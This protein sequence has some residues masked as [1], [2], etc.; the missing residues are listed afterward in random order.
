[1]EIRSKRI[2]TTLYI[3]SFKKIKIKKYIKKKIKIKN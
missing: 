3:N 1:M 2:R